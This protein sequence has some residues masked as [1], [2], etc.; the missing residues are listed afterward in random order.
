[1]FSFVISI[2]SVFVAILIFSFQLS[3]KI[4]APC[5]FLSIFFIVFGLYGIS[6]YIMQ[7][8]VNSTLFA[9][10]YNNFTPLYILIGPAL[11]LYTKKT[12]NDDTCIFC[13]VEAIH[14]IPFLF[15]LIDLSPYIFRSFEFKIQFAKSIINN[16]SNL[17]LTPHLFMSDYL[18]SILR[19]SINLIYLLFSLKLLFLPN[20]TQITSAKQKN[21]VTIWLRILIIAMTF[22]F[23]FMLL[24]LISLRLDIGHEMLDMSSELFLKITWYI[25]GGLLFTLF[26]FPQVLYGMPQLNPSNPIYKKLISG[27]NNKN[28]SEKENKKVY[29]TF[30]LEDAYLEQ[31]NLLVENYI[32]TQPF[33]QDK[34]SLSVLTTETKIPTHHLNLYFKNYLNTSFNIWK[35]KLKIDYAIELI[36]SGILNQITIEAIALKSGFKSY[37]NF[38]TVFKSQTGISPSDYIEKQSK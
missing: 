38:F 2:F 34:F 22:F 13:K 33:I 16:A 1:M 26:F 17:K 10:F 20:H 27:S 3:K 31:I 15:V 14:L 25:H 8:S 30:E 37:S 5:L 9:I 23:L 19:Q 29:K 12:L 18:G 24:Y 7:E 4:S 21:I 32:K 28:N 6:H 35:N 36:D 11:Y